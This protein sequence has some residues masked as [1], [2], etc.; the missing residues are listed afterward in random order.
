[1]IVK[2]TKDAAR[3]ILDAAWKAQWDRRIA[4]LTK[5]DWSVL[6]YAARPG[7]KSAFDIIS[8]LNRRQH[9]ARVESIRRLMNRE[10]LRNVQ[11][12]GFAAISDEGRRA[13][14]ERKQKM[15]S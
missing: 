15:A 11:G 3:A 12:S 5:M 9:P 13:L 7:M 2:P 6:A 4:E 8:T 14:D 10:F 1:M